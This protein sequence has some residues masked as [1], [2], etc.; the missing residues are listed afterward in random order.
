M[1]E[2]QMREK[3]L[4]VLAGLA[5]EV[6]VSSLKPDVRLRDQLDLD[7]MDFLNFLIGIDEQLSVDIPED[8]YGLLTT[9]DSIYAYLQEQLSRDESQPSA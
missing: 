6:D 4:A 7:S 2:Q 8:D 3:V 5:P 1:N 9:L